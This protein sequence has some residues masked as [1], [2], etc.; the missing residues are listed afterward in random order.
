MKISEQ[1]KTAL[2]LGI[3]GG[4]SGC[5]VRLCDGAGNV[6]GQGEAGAANTLLGLAKVF[7][8]I[9]AATSQALAQAGLPADTIAQLH[10]GAG[11]AGLS[12]ARERD[13]LATYPHPFATFRAEADA[14][15]ACLGAHGGDDGGIV[16]VGTGSCGLAL[17]GGEVHTVSGW[18]FALSDQ[19][20]GAAL[21]RTALRQALTE[22]DGIVGSTPLGRWIMAHFQNLPEAIFLW[23]ESASPGDYAT[24]APWVFAAADDNE[25]SAM[26]LLG[27][28]AADIARLVEAL[29][30]KGAPGVALVGG[31]SK[32]ILP[33]LPDQIRPML[34][35]ARHDPLHG[36]IML[37][38]SELVEP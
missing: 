30:A 17:V 33:W 36:A 11:L 1:D 12:L 22:H 35:A 5:R 3:D 10:A 16:V 19:G 23:A 25:G 21:G 32:P 24:F 14:Y 6:I 27:R 15:A 26:A 4:G 7:D 29:I 2:F 20:S 34:V 28:T 13:S 38:R 37:A 18:G 8:E 9:Q 31:L